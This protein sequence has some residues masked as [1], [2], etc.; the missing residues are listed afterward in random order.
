MT[1]KDGGTGKGSKHV[2]YDPDKKDEGYE[3]ID[4]GAKKIN[5]KE[6][7]KKGNKTTYKF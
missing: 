5:P 2:P 3:K 6:V 4:W 7:I 1:W